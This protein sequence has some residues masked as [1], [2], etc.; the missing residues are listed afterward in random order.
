VI[1]RGGWLLAALLWSASVHAESPSHTTAQM[2]AAPKVAGVVNLNE[3]SAD[4][5]E[6]LPG[7]GPQKARSIVEHR[8]AH[9]FLKVDEITKVKGIG[10]KTLGKL[11]PYI[12][13]VGPTTLTERS[14][15]N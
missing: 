14:S 11:R 13:L 9:R 6:R 4:E 15:K 2:V 1:A 10:R 12:T 8:H 3:A 5:L 7:I